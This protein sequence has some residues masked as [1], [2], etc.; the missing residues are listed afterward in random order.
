LQRDELAQRVADE[1][2]EREAGIDLVAS[3]IEAPRGAA[4]E[5]GGVGVGDV[6]GCACSLGWGCGC[7]C[8]LPRCR[9]AGG[10]GFSAC[11]SGL[12]PMPLRV[13]DSRLERLVDQQV[14]VASTEGDAVRLHDRASACSGRKGE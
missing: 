5:S 13:A 2:D 4:S 14:P 3:V 7:E 1:G 9:R 10:R 6:A 8:E 11:E 12:A